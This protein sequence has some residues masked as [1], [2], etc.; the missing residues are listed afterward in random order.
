M[1]SMS[2]TARKARGRTG[3]PV[4]VVIPAF[5][6]AAS[7]GAA[8]AS[9]LRQTWADFELIVV[10]DGS[11]DGT[12]EAA[13]RVPDP[14][15]RLVAN[16]G[17]LGAA[18]ARNT[19]IREARGAWVAF[20]DSD[21]EWLPLKLEKQMARLL[22]PGADFVAGFCGMMVIGRAEGQDRGRPR[23]AYLPHSGLRQVEGD[24]ERALL[25]GNFVSTQTLVARRD[26]LF[27]IGGF[28]ESLPAVE[29]WD[30]ALRLAGQGPIAFLDEPLV[31]QR[32]S[33]NS[34]SR[35]LARRLA[36]RA[37]I[38]EKHRVLYALHPEFLASV[39][40]V[41]AGCH[42][43]LGNL[44]DAQAVLARARNARPLDPWL[45]AMTMRL[46]L[47]RAAPFLF[48]PDPI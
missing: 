22:A 2:G 13:A 12:L 18:A 36:A 28:D 23:I 45:W 19:G 20:Q 24:I 39:L 21:D 26:V 42:V 46:L 27:A 7:I 1:L 4:S 17:N 6:R 8:I 34:L 25:A 14:R 43:R 47:R 16:P 41:N 33:H 15:I 35:D 30:C 9:V 29:D 48:R 3:A 32:F 31:L 5:N 11:T 44:A 10:D 37:A 40:A 38:V